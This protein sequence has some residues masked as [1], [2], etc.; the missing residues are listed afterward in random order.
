MN[1]NNYRPISLLSLLGFHIVEK[2]GKAA[3]EENA[4]NENAH[5]TGLKY[6]SDHEPPILFS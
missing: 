2:E 3:C 6:C 4:K 5:L 1:L